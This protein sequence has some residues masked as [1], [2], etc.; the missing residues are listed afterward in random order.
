MLKY[1]SF[2]GFGMFRL[3]EIKL[4]HCLIV[5]WKTLTGRKYQLVNG[6]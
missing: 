6:S 2:K 3:L 1:E 5:T 4:K